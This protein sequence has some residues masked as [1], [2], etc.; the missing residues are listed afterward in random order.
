[1]IRSL[2]RPLA[3]IA[4]LA[5]RLTLAAVLL[6]HGW[7]KLVTNGWNATAEGFAGM[8]IPLPEAAATFAIA[9]EIGGAILLVLGG[10][11]ALVGI[12]VVANM[13]GALIFAH[14]ESGVFVSDGG[15]EL[16]AMIAVAGLALAATGA[17]RISIDHAMSGSSRGRSRSR[18]AATA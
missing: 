11:T 10:F 12:L 7:Q 4:L 17:G 15:W 6:A 5:V 16:V 1:M 9:V 8:G 13:L 18:S 14:A 2:P 3:D